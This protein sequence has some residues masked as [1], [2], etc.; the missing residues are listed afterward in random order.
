MGFFDLFTKKRESSDYTNLVSRALQEAAA[1]TSAD[2]TAVS[3]LE[4]ASGLWA[5]SLATAV[6]T[7]SAASLAVSPE[8]LATV[9]RAL[10]RRGDFVALIDVDRA[11][12]LRLLPATAWDVT[13]GASP[14]SW[15][16]QVTLGAPSGTETY[17]RN[18]EAVVHLRFGVEPSRPWRGLSPLHVRGAT[19]GRL[20]A[21]A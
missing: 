7:P 8:F 2:P 9:G 13:G 5:R 18:A 17:Q 14:A 21:A 3:A 20:L 10:I 1:G 11:G 4:T 12:S 6:V 16:Y 15:R 19:R